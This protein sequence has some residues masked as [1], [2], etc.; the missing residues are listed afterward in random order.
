M[1][2]GRDSGGPAGDLSSRAAGI[3]PLSIFDKPE[4][5]PQLCFAL[6]NMTLMRKYVG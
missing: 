3:T 6:F 1:T 4:I 2:S 5:W